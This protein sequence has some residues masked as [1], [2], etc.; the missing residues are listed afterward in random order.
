VK[1]RNSCSRELED[2]EKKNYISHKKE[3]KE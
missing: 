1:E 2:E 3:L